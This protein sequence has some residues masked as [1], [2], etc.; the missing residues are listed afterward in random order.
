MRYCAI[1]RIALSGQ[2][3]LV[4]AELRRCAA[5]LDA[6]DVAAR[7]RMQVQDVVTTLHELEARWFIVR[8]PASTV[9]ERYTLA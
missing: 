3:Q 4:L 7:T 2:E 1:M 5:P 8:A 6:I 9:H